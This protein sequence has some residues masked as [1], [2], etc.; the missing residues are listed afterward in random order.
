MAKSILIGHED[1]AGTERATELGA[2]IA[3][4]LGSW[5]LGLAI[6]DVP[7]IT[8]GAA[9]GIG[10]SSFKV[11]RDKT[12]IEDARRRAREYEDTFMA[13]CK[14]LDV[15]ARI[16]ET[17]GRPA[18]TILS[19]L[20]NHDMF[21]LGRDA[22]FQFETEAED[23]RTWDVVLHRAPKPVIVV[24]ETET[25]ATGKVVIAYD[26]SVAA[27]RALRA[28]VSTGLAKGRALHVVT[29]NASGATAW[30]VANDAV[31][32]LAD[33]GHKAEIHNVVSVLPTADA[34]LETAVK[35]GAEM[36]VMGAFAHSRLRS[37]FRGSATQHLVEK[38]TIPLFLT[39]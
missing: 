11:D 39:H 5:L 20:H 21:M 34:L 23:R 36:I 24:P 16:L 19:E 17:T 30:E 15:T 3:K 7:D 31:E 26:G 10:G 6:I 8:A 22:N 9:M 29:V 18:E 25:P 35:I 37:L 2:A 1:S 13:R 28:F 33:L 38:T 12:L 32:G 4:Q 27:M 14:R